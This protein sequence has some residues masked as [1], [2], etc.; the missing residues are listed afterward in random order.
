MQQGKIK[1]RNAYVLI[2]ERS[3]CI[4]LVRYNEF[5]DDLQVALA[6]QDYCA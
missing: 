5:T 2:Y 6:K 1:N 3:H 4:D